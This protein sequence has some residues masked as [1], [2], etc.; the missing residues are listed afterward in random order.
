MK[1]MVLALIFTVLLSAGSVLNGVAQQKIGYINSNELIMAMPERDSAMTMVE[2]KR[3]DFL[4]QSEE[5]Q[6]E[7]NKKYEDYLMK[8]DSL[9][10]LIRSTKENELGD[11]RDRIETFNAAADQELQRFNQEVFQPIIERA[12]QAIKDVAIEQ[13][14][15]YILDLSQAAVIYYPEEGSENILLAVK[16]KLGLE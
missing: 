1:K 5:L 7:F 16:K 9:S 3:Q 11:L 6:V 8:Q 4:R 10:P 12:Q 2:Q 13:G 14:F 15:T